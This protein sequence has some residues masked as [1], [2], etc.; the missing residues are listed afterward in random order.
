MQL[1]G[2]DVDMFSGPIYVRD[3]IPVGTSLETNAHVSQV[4]I[5]IHACLLV[6]LHSVP[7][8]SLG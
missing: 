8:T 2:S 5:I 3:G 4:E 6:T 1:S 7:T